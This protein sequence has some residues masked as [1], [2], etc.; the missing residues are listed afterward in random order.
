MGDLN[1][2]DF[3]LENRDRVKGPILEIGSRDYG[4]TNDLRG[5][6]PG[7]RYLGVDM[8]PGKGVDLVCDFVD[9]LEVVDARLDGARFQTVVCFSV[10][11]HC[12]QPFRMAE[13][14]TA[15]TEPGGLLFLSVPWVW[16]MHGFPDDYWRF[17]PSAVRVLFPR[18]RVVEER[19]FWSTKNRG[20]RLPLSVKKLNVHEAT[21]F[22]IP[23]LARALRR[24]GLTNF[25]HP[26]YCY[27]VM[28]NML[29]ERTSAEP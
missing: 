5:Y 24:L 9:P 27:P 28:L 26:Y 23:A 29:L 21:F 14:I 6:F 7:L 3:V 22:K 12:R 16:N 15:L 10:M 19:S 20:E 1:Q 18:F 17:T 8:E 25:R 11:E 4:N 2:L 13:N